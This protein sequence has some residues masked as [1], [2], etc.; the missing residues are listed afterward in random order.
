[1]VGRVEDWEGEM[2]R[3]EAGDAGEGRGSSGMNRVK[4]K[5][6]INTGDAGV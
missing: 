5:I 1:M 2:K 6:E 4:T 3:D